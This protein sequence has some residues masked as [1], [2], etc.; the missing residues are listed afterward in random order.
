MTPSLNPHGNPASTS[1]EPLGAAI[2][3]ASQASEPSPELV[4]EI[5]QRLHRLRQQIPPSV[6][7]IAVSKTFGPEVVRAGYKAGL[8]D[9]AENK[10]QEALEKQSAL[11]DLPDV[12]WHFIGRLQSNKTRKILE[13]FDWIHSIDSLKL[14]ER[15]ERQAAEL[16]KCPHCYLQ[17]KLMADPTKGG[18]EVAAL[19]SALPRLCK[20][21]HLNIVGLMVIPPSG[22]SAAQTQAVFEQA[23]ELAQQ[24]NEQTQGKLPTHEL[25]MG[26][27]GDFKLA[28][29]AGS[30]AL[31]IGSA[32]FGQRPRK[33]IGENAS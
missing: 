12:T 28:I 24:I 21:T 6:R 5:T 16:G 1:D 18:F 15:L 2:S 32:L 11:G 29:A 20:L 25:S 30:T 4:D 27:S 9:F 13:N 8:R 23:R 14:A 17:V 3:G 26:M 7:L 10:V 22:L 19:R 31:R 33:V